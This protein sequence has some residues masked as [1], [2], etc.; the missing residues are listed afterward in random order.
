[1]S[2]YHTSR[3]RSLP[4][5]ATATA[6]GVNFALL[7]KHGS[8]VHLVLYGLE[9][10][11]ALAEFGRHPR[12]NRTGDHWH[13]HVAGLPSAFRYGWRVNGLN[14]AGNR[15]DPGLVLLDP[16]ATAVSDGAVWGAGARSVPGTR[17]GSRRA[18]RRS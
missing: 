1:M 7:C 8:E 3:G 6:D 9:T 5:G 17:P 10:S 11:A 18:P 16:C 15:F 13:I 14:V 12:M 4:L 2:T